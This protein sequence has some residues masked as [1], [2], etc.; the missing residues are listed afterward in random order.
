MQPTDQ[1]IAGIANLLGSFAAKQMQ[2]THG[3]VAQTHSPGAATVWIKEVHQSSANDG[4]TSE[5]TYAAQFWCTH[6]FFPPM[7]G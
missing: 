5:Q 7:L 2:P 6:F 4:A 1:V 3:F